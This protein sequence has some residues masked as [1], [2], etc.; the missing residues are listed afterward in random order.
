[1]AINESETIIIFLS[2][3]FFIMYLIKIRI[4]YDKYD[5]NNSSEGKKVKKRFK[6]TS[7]NKE[8]KRVLEAIKNDIRKYI[9]REKRKTLPNDMDMW[10]MDCKFAIKR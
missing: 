9:K 8:P 1:M 2:D 3:L 5:Y 4:E 10:N 7:E 6:L